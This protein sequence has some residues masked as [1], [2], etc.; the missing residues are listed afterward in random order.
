MGGG[1]DREMGGR[2]EEEGRWWGGGGEVGGRWGGGGSIVG[3]EV[4]HP[5]E[6]YTEEKCGRNHGEFA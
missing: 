2:W 3:G 6:R 5:Q 4:G 1:R